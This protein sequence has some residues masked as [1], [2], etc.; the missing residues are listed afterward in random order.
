VLTTDEADLA[1]L[2][3]MSRSSVRV[4]AV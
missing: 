4:V 3:A 1:P 2:A